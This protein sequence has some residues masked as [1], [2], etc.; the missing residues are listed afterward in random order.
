MLIGFYLDKFT[1]I[2]GKRNPCI[3]KVTHQCNSN[4][5]K[6]YWHDCN[7]YSIAKAIHNY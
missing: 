1:I 6:L 5:T 4:N 7:K 2:V 3:S